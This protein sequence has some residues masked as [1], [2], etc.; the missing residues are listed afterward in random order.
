MKKIFFILCFYVFWPSLSSCMALDLGIQAQVNNLKTQSICDDVSTQE[1]TRII[2]EEKSQILLKQID[3]RLIKIFGSSELPKNT[4]ITRQHQDSLRDL[5]F[6]YDEQGM[7]SKSLEIYRLTLAMTRLAG[8]GEAEGMSLHDLGFSYKNLKQYPEALE[9][10]Q[11][12][13]RIAKQDQSDLAEERQVA[14][15]NNIGE[16]YRNLK[17]YDRALMYYHQGLAIAK[18]N[19]DRD[20]QP[21]LEILLKNIEEV[22]KL[23][24]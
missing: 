4:M 3:E 21:F 1:S 18:N 9:C 6:H 22:K 13:L 15:L 8:G 16:V 11:K 17:Q 24:E 14:C 23:S 7:Y 10:Y 5:G 20:M 12:A 19:Q 2:Q